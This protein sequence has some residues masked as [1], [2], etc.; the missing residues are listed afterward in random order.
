M[1]SCFHYS[2]LT[3]RAVVATM[4][5]PQHPSTKNGKTMTLLSSLPACWHWYIIGIIAFGVMMT[6]IALG[7]PAFL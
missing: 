1:S 2:A 5:R 7:T 3:Q 6:A 4:M